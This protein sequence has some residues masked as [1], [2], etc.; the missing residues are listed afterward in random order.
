[1]NTERK[2]LGRHDDAKEWLALHH[3]LYALMP[4]TNTAMPLGT[5]GGDEY[6]D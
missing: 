2:E 3:E 6:G 4:P 1:M 5:Y